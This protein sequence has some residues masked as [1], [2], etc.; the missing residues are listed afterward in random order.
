M[1]PIILQATTTTTILLLSLLLST[2]TTTTADI[3]LDTRK[4]PVVAGSYYSVVSIFFTE[5]GADVS[6]GIT[7]FN[8]G[9]LSCPSFIV[10]RSEI[11]D[12]HIKFTPQ[13]I[14]EKNYVYT[15]SN[16]NIAFEYLKPEP[17][18]HRRYTTV[19]TVSGTE[20]GNMV[21]LDGEEGR[22]GSMFKLE[23]VDYLTFPIYSIWYGDKAVLYD[24]QPNGETLLGLE[25]GYPFLVWLFLGGP[26]TS[27]L[28]ELGIKL[29]GVGANL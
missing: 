8:N 14:T 20:N 10:A 26:S 21:V 23:K 12:I 2:P 7:M 19:W 29:K 15:S 27:A 13:T 22:D 5:A 6:L 11:F 25:K 3:V 4:N 24:E 17:D 28:A 1:I 9:T 18:C 16:L